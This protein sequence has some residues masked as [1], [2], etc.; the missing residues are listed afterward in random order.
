[1][2]QADTQS[3]FLSV[4]NDEPI[5]DPPIANQEVLDWNLKLMD[6]IK[7]E[8]K[9]LN[10]QTV[11]EL[12]WDTLNSGK[13]IPGFGHAVLRKTDPRYTVQHQFC[14]D[15][16]PNDELFQ[17]TN[18][19]YNVMPKVLTEHGKTKNPWPNVDAMSGTPLHHFGLQETNFYTVL[20]GIS[21]AIGTLSQ[22]V[23][24]RRSGHGLEQGLEMDQI[25]N[26]SIESP[27]V[28]LYK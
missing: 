12:A 3:R 25:N 4:C 5:N 20:F 7:K 11:T 1:M 9:P 28:T 6:R 19:I 15:N 27:F 18:H 23:V 24:D 13:V 2:G 16:I 14:L 21:R 22:Y 10:E 8:G 17:L 26:N